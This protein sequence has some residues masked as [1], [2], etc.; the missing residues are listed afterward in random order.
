MSF[1]GVLVAGDGKGQGRRRR[2]REEGNTNNNNK[3]KKPKL[4]N[5]D[6]CVKQKNGVKGNG[7][8]CINLRPTNP[9]R[10]KG[11]P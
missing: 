3:G 1:D 4:K 9:H 10:L 2:R 8:G 5:E 11:E 7:L 6:R